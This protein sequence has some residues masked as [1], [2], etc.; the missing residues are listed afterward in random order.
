[1]SKLPQTASA[2]VA[3]I[4]SL[5]PCESFLILRRVAHPE[6]PWS[7]HFSFPGGRKE[8]HDPDLLATC[9]RETKEETG[10]LLNAAQ[11]QRRFSLEPAGLNLR[12]PLWVQPFLFT[13]SS[14]PPLSLCRR[15]I[16]GAYWLE[17]QLFQNMDLHE[18]VEMAP[19]RLFPAY[20]LDDYYLWGFTY[21]LLQ[22]VL[23][24]DNTQ[25]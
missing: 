25:K 9:I 8:A 22:T 20:P 24:T 3:I 23:R 6:D 4:K 7:G 14:P 13:I 19:G 1:M 5:A 21:R 16:Q 11:L 15:E 12:R 17:T 10:I 18:D 2:A